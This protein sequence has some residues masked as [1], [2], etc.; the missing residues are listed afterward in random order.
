MISGVVDA[1]REALVS[2]P[3]RGPGRQEQI[4]QAVI[5]TGFTGFLTLPSSLVEALRLPRIGRSRALL[6]SGQ[7]VLLDLHEAAILWDGRWLTVEVDSV[8]AEALV[9]MSLLAGYSLYLEAVAGGRVTIE[10]LA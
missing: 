8:D 3:V 1:R 4:V 10:L 9:G 7:E 6:A 5:D 2:L